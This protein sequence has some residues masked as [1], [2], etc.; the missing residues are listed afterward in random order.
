M[1]HWDESKIRRG[2]AGKFAPKGPSE[3]DTS[4]ALGQHDH[5]EALQALDTIEQRFPRAHALSLRSDGTEHQLQRVLSEE[6]SILWRNRPGH[7]ASLDS[8]AAAIEGAEIPRS[9]RGRSFTHYTA[10]GTEHHRQVS[11]DALRTA[12]GSP[13][14]D[15]PTGQS[16]N[17][18]E[19]GVSANSE[20]Y[21]QVAQRLMDLDAEDRAAAYF[22]AQR[23]GR[24]A[25]PDGSVVEV[26]DPERLMRWME[27]YESEM[28]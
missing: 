9:V 19:A 28:P 13:R 23:D 6:G 8:A 21:R 14:P 1:T 18:P 7:D 10:A 11:L 17:E 25:M 15:T 4:I 2:A 16:P 22:D 5:G 3:E 27:H 12:W 24:V 20:H 26:E